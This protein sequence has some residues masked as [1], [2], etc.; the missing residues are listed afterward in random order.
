[1]THDDSAGLF[2]RPNED[3][4]REAWRTARA[5]HS[6]GAVKQL[7]DFAI[8][9]HELDLSTAPNAATPSHLF[10]DAM[11][12][13]GS[14]PG[15]ENIEQACRVAS[16]TGRAQPHLAHLLV[17]HHTP[18]DLVIVFDDRATPGDITDL[19][20]CLVQEL[21]IRAK[22]LP[23]PATAW[24]RS[25][26]QW[27]RHPLSWLPLSLRPMET[28]IEELDFDVDTGGDA[29]CMRG[30]LVNPMFAFHPGVHVPSA[31]E[32]TSPQTTRATASPTVLVKHEARTFEFAE[33]VGDIPHAFASLPLESLRGLDRTTIDTQE[34]NASV[35]RFFAGQGQLREPENCL[36]VVPTHLRDAWQ[37]LY[38]ASIQGTATRRPGEY[39]AFARLAVWRSLAGMTDTIGGTAFEVEAAAWQHQWFDIEITTDWFEERGFGIATLHPDRRRMAVLMATSSL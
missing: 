5:R 11:E 1:M 27:H 39:S 26:P 15:R 28:N 34:F 10:T 25:S 12:T 8:R 35:M 24:T 13:L 33:P 3:E 6:A 17:K 18:D 23:K 38:S 32:T 21:V 19:R 37:L 14:S 36:S 22:Q 29:P 20:A 16:L 30:G 31:K 2:G 9:L 7:A 4:L